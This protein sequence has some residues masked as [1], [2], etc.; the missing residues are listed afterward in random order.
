MTRKETEMKGKE[1]RK[2]DRE[3]G[4]EE[5]RGK[6]RRR[7]E[8]WITD[9]CIPLCSSITGREHQGQLGLSGERRD[10]K[11]FSRPSM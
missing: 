3:V 7:E 9:L 1:D 6:G 11:S 4:R 2:K 5:R 8:R 10:G